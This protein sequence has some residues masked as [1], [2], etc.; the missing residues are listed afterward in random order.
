MTIIHLFN[1][2]NSKEVIG[3]YEVV[4]NVFKSTKHSN[5][6]SNYCFV[7]WYIFPLKLFLIFHSFK[8]VWSNRK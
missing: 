1:K 6:I 5:N 7:R 3:I 4:S 2:P 8:L